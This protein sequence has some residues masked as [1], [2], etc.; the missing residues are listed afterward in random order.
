M[1]L[2]LKRRAAEDRALSCAVMVPRLMARRIISA[3][4]G[5][6]LDVGLQHLVV[7][8]GD[9]LDHPRAGRPRPSRAVAPGSPRSPTPHPSRRAS[10]TAFMLTRSMTPRESLLDAH[11]YLHGH[12]FRVEPRLDHLAPTSRSPAPTRSI[13]FT[14]H[15]RGT[16]YLSACRQTVSVCGST[17]P[18]AQKIATAPSSTRS[19]L[20]TSIVKSTW[21]GVSIMLIRCLP[22]RR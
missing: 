13:L 18:T 4:I 12:R 20:S 11:R 22:T 10:T 1:P 6:V 7:E 21:P 5:P 15:I 3:A 14:K 16:L 2:F 17:P 9:L 8:I 19:D